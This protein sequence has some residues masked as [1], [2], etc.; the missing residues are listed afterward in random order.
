MDGWM[1]NPL[2][3]AHL[4]INVERCE[5]ARANVTILGNAVRQGRGKPLQT[6]VAPLR[7]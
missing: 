6:Q 5:F 4:T 7:Q 2:A 3:G 1:F